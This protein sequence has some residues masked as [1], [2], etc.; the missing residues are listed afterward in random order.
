MGVDGP[1]ER[2]GVPGLPPTFV[3]IVGAGAGRAALPGRGI[4]GLGVE[5]LGALLVVGIELAFVVCGV[6]GLG[7]GACIDVEVEGVD[8]VGAAPVAACP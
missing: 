3:D 7:A 8:A 6:A 2:N 1:P 5:D 4:E